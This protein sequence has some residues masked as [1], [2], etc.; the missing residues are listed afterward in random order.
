LGFSGVDDKGRPVVFRLSLPTGEW[1]TIASPVTNLFN[2]VEWNEDGT[3][4]YFVRSRTAE[5]NG[6]FRRSV[7]G[8]GE[9]LLYA[10]APSARPPAGLQISPNR[11]WLAFQHT[12]EGTG[13]PS[14]TQVI[15]VNTASGERRT[16]TSLT[17]TGS[18]GERLRLSGWSPDGRVLVQRYLSGSSLPANWELVPLDGGASEP[19]SL[20]IPAGTGAAPTNQP[21]AKWSP[22]GSAIAFVQI[23]SS[24]RVFLLENPLADLPAAKSGAT[25]R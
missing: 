3:A 10:L 7:E 22:N 16:V 19:L 2:S 25:R 17:S 8:G 11:R 9:E 12:V 15:V 5:Q 4:F 24:E 20:A 23:A 6:V 18:V 13:G 21:L 1:A 14:E